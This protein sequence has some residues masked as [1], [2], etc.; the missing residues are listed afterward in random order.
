MIDRIKKLIEQGKNLN[1][2]DKNGEFILHQAVKEKNLKAV[3]ILVNLG[4]DVNQTDA[5]GISAL[6]HAAWTGKG[7]IAK[8][9]IENGAEIDAQNKMGYTPLMIAT[10]QSNIEVAKMLLEKNADVKKTNLEGET[11]LL[12]AVKNNELDI[13]SKLIDAQS[14]V[15][16][17]NNYGMDAL[18]LASLL[19]YKEMALLLLDKGA[20][21][22]NTDKEGNTALMMASAKGYL[23]IVRLLVERGADLSFKNKKGLKA[24]EVAAE[25]SQTDVVH[26]FIDVMGEEALDPKYKKLPK[27]FLN[28]VVSG[29][30]DI[31]KEMMETG[32]DINA[33]DSKGVTPLMAAAF[34]G[35]E[36]LVDY[37]IEEGADLT[38]QSFEGLTAMDYAVQNERY[39][40]AGL[41]KR[42]IENEKKNPRIFN[43]I[44]KGSVLHLNR[45]IELGFD[46]NVANENGDTPLMEAIKKAD[47][48][49][50]KALLSAGAFVTAQ[51]K[52]GEGILEQ[53]GKSD[54]PAFKMVQM[55]ALLKE[56]D[57]PVH[58][59]LKNSKEMI[60]DVILS[61]VKTQE[62]KKMIQNLL[63]SLGLK[64]AQPAKKSKTN[65][66]D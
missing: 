62:E 60:Y 13:V 37:F 63:T 36:S 57:A 34:T 59:K 6:M 8:I 22:K 25:Y 39:E 29:D 1:Q 31:V 32:I 33:V 38:K 30:I 43:V 66:R 7:D 55:V 28:A 5:M 47:I 44:Q 16:H 15:Q 10:L 53:I 9:L 54:A 3:Q 20:H 61:H 4:V 24:V 35:R 11:P 64:S 19:G 26:Y 21:L 48:E 58:Q 45:F 23:D 51:N 46:V 65:S 14:N 18:M 41:I 12:I 2:P 56:F 27:R 52:K 50:V 49:M 42:S 40:I 17:Q